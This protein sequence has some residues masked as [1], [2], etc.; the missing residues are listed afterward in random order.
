MKNHAHFSSTLSPIWKTRNSLMDVTTRIRMM[1]LRHGVSRE[2]SERG[3]G[4]SLTWPGDGTKPGLHK[5][6]SD[7][8]VLCSPLFP[9]ATSKP[10]IGWVILFSAPHLT[11]SFQSNAVLADCGVGRRYNLNLA[12]RGRKPPGNCEVSPANNRLR[13]LGPTLKILKTVTALKFNTWKS[14]LGPATYFLKA[15]KAPAGS[16][17]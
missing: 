9:K 11:C 10:A 4:E 17:I 16:G 13:Y 1:E 6:K 5:R 7:T 14:V 3:W 8:L 2:K 12:W 15:A